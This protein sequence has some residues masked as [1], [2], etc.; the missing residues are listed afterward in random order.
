MLKNNE[1]ILSNISESK[2]SEREENFLKNVLDSYY[3][4]LKNEYKQ[5]KE[6]ELSNSN[7][8][9]NTTAESSIIVTSR[10]NDRKI[11]KDKEKTKKQKL[12]K[13]KKS[14]PENSKRKSAYSECESQKKKENNNFEKEELN[15]AVE[16]KI[17]FKPENSENLR[18]IKIIYGE[19]ERSENYF[20]E[21]KKEFSKY[22]NCER[23]KIFN[24]LSEFLDRLINDYKNNSELI[25]D[26][27][28]NK[29]NN[30][31]E[32]VYN[33]NSH[34]Y[35][36][37]NY[38][39]EETFCY[40]IDEINCGK[41]YQKKN[42]KVKQNKQ[43]KQKNSQETQNDEPT[44]LHDPTKKI[45]K[46]HKY[47][48]LCFDKVIGEHGEHNSAT[49]IKEL[50]N[51][52]YTYI[53]GGT[54]KNLKLYNSNFFRENICLIDSFFGDVYQ[55]KSLKKEKES[56]ENNDII[57]YVSKKKDLSIYEF[58]DGKFYNKFIIDN[59]NCNSLVQIQ[60]ED[61]ES[62]IIAGKGGVTRINNINNFLN[63]TGKDNRYRILKDPEFVGIIQIDKNL[64][65]LTSNKSLPR[66]EDK[67]VIY[68]L[69]KS[70]IPKEIKDF[71][72]IIS[73][74]GLA[75]LIPGVKSENEKDEENKNEKDEKYL[76]CACKK[77]SADQK[78]GILFINVS[79]ENDNKY[80][81][82][83]YNTEDFEVH[84]F[85]QIMERQYKNTDT[86][87]NYN[88]NTMPTD[89]FL[90]GGFSQRKRE[91]LIK[92]YKLNNNENS[93]EREIKFL[94]DIEFKKNLKLDDEEEDK[95]QQISK[96]SSQ[97]DETVDT[98]CKNNNNDNEIF[99]GFNGAI[100][101]IIQSSQSLNI[102]TSCYDGKISL[103]SNINLEM[104]K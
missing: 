68:D 39:S 74:N 27:K 20:Y 17:K 65:A 93:K 86:V 15:K 94:Q 69:E 23:Y 49:F 40:F 57:F 61:N 18:E 88:N 5:K 43:N 81:H 51:T 14:I 56:D 102:L 85:C 47:K 22:K 35:K 92:L 99:K 55:T 84:C 10:N 79:N 96:N 77:Y 104:Y 1:E 13:D 36:D 21:R 91:G 90:V 11:T 4:Y 66:G 3:D 12:N 29:I 48:I 30:E 98:T 71:S 58:K 75:K 7:I 42:K 63:N 73:S 52:K 59:I 76:I 67:L 31:F 38:I 41:Y 45:I 72:F 53:S 50:N 100:S 46:N 95:E 32:F 28:I 2:L 101:S 83:F 24:Y 62:L 9:L 78:N 16:I 8:E 33:F 82:K 60:D 26:L 25:I 80:N 64:I 87:N 89:Y 97:L 103:F 44:V 19:T 6:K 37:I 70:T 54:D 34:S